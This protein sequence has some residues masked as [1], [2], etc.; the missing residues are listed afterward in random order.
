MNPIIAILLMCCAVWFGFTFVYFIKYLRE[1]TDHEINSIGLLT[2]FM[3]DLKNIYKFYKYFYEAHSI[4]YDK[5]I[6]WF[7]IISN[8]FSPICFWIITITAYFYTA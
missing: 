4:K 6:T 8:I 3:G 1:N 7:L 2:S 5:K